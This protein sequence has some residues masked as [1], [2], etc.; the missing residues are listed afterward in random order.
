MVCDRCASGALEQAVRRIDD[1][2]ARR[3]VDL[4]HGG[5]IERHQFGFAAGAWTH[6]YQIAGAEI[7]DGHDGAERGAGA[8][9][10]RKADQVGVVELVGRFGAPSG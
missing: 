3:D 1:D 5:V 8:I 4:G 2:A 7:M 6:L 10:D 9:D